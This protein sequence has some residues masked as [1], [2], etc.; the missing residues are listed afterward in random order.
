MTH[1]GKNPKARPSRL[2]TVDTVF[3]GLSEGL[4]FE[5]R[6]GRVLLRMQTH[7][8]LLRFP[9]LGSHSSDFGVFMCD[10][11]ECGSF[12]FYGSVFKHHVDGCF[13][14]FSGKEENV[15]MTLQYM[16]SVEVSYH[17]PW[18]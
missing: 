13:Q 3:E 9:E 11:L 5:D 18:W 15:T 16:T 1:P 14:Y 12:A 10:M 7:N 6:S 4:A 2:R 17:H 8:I